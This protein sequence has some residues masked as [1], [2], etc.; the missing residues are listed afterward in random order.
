MPFPRIGKR[1]LEPNLTS[2]ASRTKAFIA[3]LDH[4]R[5]VPKM[6]PRTRNGI[7][8]LLPSLLVHDLDPGRSLG[9]V[10]DLERV[11]ETRSARDPTLGQD[12]DPDPLDPNLDLYL[13]QSTRATVHILAQR[14]DPDPDPDHTHLTGTRL[15]R[16]PMRIHNETRHASHGARPMISRRIVAPG[17]R[18]TKRRMRARKLEEEDLGTRLQPRRISPTMTMTTKTSQDQP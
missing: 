6:V 2:S 1:S 5:L 11:P 4:G 8:L 15:T 14:P 3:D 16:D 12:Q 17:S 18:W 10:L 9:I 7:L 13:G